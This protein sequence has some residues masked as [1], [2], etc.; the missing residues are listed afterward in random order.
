MP[1]CTHV[2]VLV[3]V[4]L[5]IPQGWLGTKPMVWVLAATSPYPREQPGRQVAKII[6]LAVAA[7]AV[8]VSRALHMF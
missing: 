4:D 3:I 8:P 2:P 1:H 5:A 6:G 7:P